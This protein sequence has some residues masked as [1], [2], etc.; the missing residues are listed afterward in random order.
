MLCPNLR[1]SAQS[2]DS[3]IASLTSEIA[4]KLG[5][6]NKPTQSAF[7][8]RQARFCTPQNKKVATTNPTLYRAQVKKERFGLLDVWMF[9]VF[10]SF[11]L[12]AWL[13]C[14]LSSVPLT[15]GSDHRIRGIGHCGC[16]SGRNRKTGIAP[17]CVATSARP[18][19]ERWASSPGRSASAT[20]P[21]RE[22]PTR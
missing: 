17:P 5:L 12:A 3:R 9:G 16:R 1:K 10:V 6:Q 20:R 14:C 8:T 4:S 15:I 22:R 2:A 21:K 13:P 11:C 19:R 18:G 7:L